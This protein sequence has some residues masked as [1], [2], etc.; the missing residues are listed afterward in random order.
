MTYNTIL[1]D[2]DGTLIASSPGILAG[3]AYAL[4]KF[5]IIE[6]D[7]KNL[8]RFVGPP[9]KESFAEFYGFDEEKIDRAVSYFREYY[10]SKGMYENALYDGISDL[11]A[12]L[13]AAGKTLIVTTSK[14]EPVARKIAEHLKIADYFD[15]IAG[16]TPDQ[17]RSKKADVIA[18]AMQEE[19]LQAK[20]LIMIGD[21]KFDVIGA[22][23]NDIAT[24]GV[25]YGYGSRQELETAGASQIVSTVADLK[26]V[27]L[28]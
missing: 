6:S 14:T 3:V 10:E 5:G 11:L 22:K 16:S 15:L 20:D 9:I 13:K 4:E 25:L 23:Q 21:R 1:F 2:M 27:L 28:A 26:K 7:P 17:S 19:K 12:S 18:Y 24:I 8:L